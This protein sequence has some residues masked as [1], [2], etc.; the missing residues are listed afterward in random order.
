MNYEASKTTTTL[1]ISY[2]KYL[3][4]TSSITVTLKGAPY[5]WKK[6]AIALYGS[7][8]WTKFSVTSFEQPCVGKLPKMWLFHWLV[9]ST[10]N[11]QLVIPCAG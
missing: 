3:E 1:Q 10:V 6:F 4:N 8:D 7:K 2:A 5:V 11:T 9:K